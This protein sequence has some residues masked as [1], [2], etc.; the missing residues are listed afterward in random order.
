MKGQMRTVHQITA[1]FRSGDAISNA[2]LQMRDVFR[3]WGCRSDILSG[4]TSIAPEMKDQA[5]AIGDAA[6]E[7]GPDDVAVLHL[8]IGNDV[9][10][11]FRDLRC[12]KAIV[13][14]NITPSRYFRFLDPRTAADL[15]LGR[16]HLAMFAGMADVNL[17]DS[18]YNAD[19]MREAGYSDV[20]VLPLP[21]DVDSFV[22]GGI[23]AHTMRLL[24]G[25]PRNVLFVGRCAPNKKLESFLAVAYHLARIVPGTRFVHVGSQGGAEAYYGLVQAYGNILGLKNYID[26]KGVSQSALNACYA[27][28]DAFLCVSE[29]E[30]FCAPLVEAMFHRV[31]VFALATSAVPETLGGAGMLF[32]PPFDPLLIAESIAE[33][34]GNGELREA[35]LRRQDERIASFRNRDLDGEMRALFAPVMS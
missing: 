1:G 8:S 17:A 33:V 16:K 24:G 6:G 25:G 2:A 13:Y 35:I 14:H 22:K 30:G 21:I 5:R 32:D 3:S 15:D 23:D 9:N 29:H 11:A 4:P 7:L 10:L 26:L 34:F 19:E 27:S 12:R 18:E 31:P 20:R 28:A